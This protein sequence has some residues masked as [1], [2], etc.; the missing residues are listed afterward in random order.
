[1]PR[2]SATS[3][4]PVIACLNEVIAKHGRWGFWKYFHWMRLKGETWNHKRVLRVYRAMKLSLSRRAKRRLPARVRQCPWWAVTDRR[5]AWL[6]G[7]NVVAAV[8]VGWV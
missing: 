3:E 2:V 4:L 6:D 1:M 5:R 8:T 7:P